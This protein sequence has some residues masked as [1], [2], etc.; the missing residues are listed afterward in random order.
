MP[1][2]FS[3]K[4]YKKY[5]NKLKNIIF[6]DKISKKEETIELN[7]NG[8]NINGYDRYGYNINGL[9]IDGTD[10]NNINING[11]TGTMMKY[12]YKDIKYTIGNNGKLY[13]QY[14]F[15]E[16]GFNIYVFNIY[17]FNRNGFNRN[18]YDK[19][20]FDA[21]GYNKDG[22]DEYGQ[23]RKSSGKGLTITTLPMLLSELITNSSK[24]LINDIEQLVKYLYDKKQIT[25]QV[26]NN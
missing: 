26:Y 3:V 15:D 4:L 10:R 25:K 17:G 7:E 5:I 16:D 6:R 22:V 23:K 13:D 2:T 12:P 21:E 9:G 1:D 24:K 19:Y 14:E 8:F 18:G 11:I 20:G